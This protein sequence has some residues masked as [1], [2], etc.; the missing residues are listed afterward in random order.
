MKENLDKKNW[1]E[2]LQEAIEA[3]KKAEVA[4]EDIAGWSGSSGNWGLHWSLMKVRE[5]LTLLTSPIDYDK[6]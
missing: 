3:L 4:M 1:E 2:L 6:K 5:S